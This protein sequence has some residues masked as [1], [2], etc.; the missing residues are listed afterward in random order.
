MAASVFASVRYYLLLGLPPGPSTASILCF[1]D[2]GC[3]AVPQGGAREHSS[4][5]QVKGNQTNQARSGAPCSEA[6]LCTRGLSRPRTRQAAP[7]RLADGSNPRGGVAASSPHLVADD[8]V[9]VT[10]PARPERRPVQLGQA[11]AEVC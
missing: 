9:R 4:C 3:R 10:A 6:G 5:Q 2:P 11:D 7:R 8:G 1:A